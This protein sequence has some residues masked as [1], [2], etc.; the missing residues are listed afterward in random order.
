M[1][2]S[3]QTATFTRFFV[4]EPKAEDFWNFFDEQ[5]RAGAFVELAGD[6]EA[7]SGFCSFDDLFDSTFAYGA[8][9]KG[10]Y[11]AFHFRSDQR[12]VPSIILKQYVRQAVEKYRTENGRWPARPEKQNIREEVQLQ[13]LARALPHPGGCEIVW[14]P[15]KQWLLAGTAGGKTLDLFLEHFEK[16]FKLYPLPLYHVHWALNMLPLTGR[17]KDTLDSM[18]SV[19]SPT[20]MAEGRFLGFDFLTWLWFF[21]EQGTDGGSIQI[22]EKTAALH[23]GERVVLVMQ[24]EGR[25][26]VVCTTQANALHE[27]RTALR[28]GKVVEELQVFIMAG[29]NEYLLT[30]D[31]GLWALKGLKTPKQ[32]PNYSEDDPDGRFFE[33]MFFLEE[34]FAVLDALY[35]K[36]LGER[37]DPGWESDTLPLIKN[38]IAGKPEDPRAR[39]A[40]GSKPPF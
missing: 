11:A 15:G 16:Y 38:W 31:S 35:L 33:K 30:L 6:Q 14:N 5:L 25:E 9:R 2:I 37:L 18:V 27:A 19:N 12:K 20:A 3:A 24:G 23:L 22:G 39:S 7:A 32:L 4:P 13:L 26:R 1:G 8:Y 10:E 36:F 40:T 17:Q 34:V 21:I 28:Q 29:E